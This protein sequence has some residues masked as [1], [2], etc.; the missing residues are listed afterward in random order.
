MKMAVAARVEAFLQEQGIRF[1]LIA[2]RLSGS[3]HETALSAHVAD[4][5]IAKAVVVRDGRGDALAVLPGD[6]WLDL[7]ALNRDTARDFRLGAEGELARLFPD[8]AEG[9]VP[10]V[11]A[12]YGLETFL[13]EALTSLANVYFEAGDHRHLVHVSGDA[14]AALLAGA[15]RGHFSGVS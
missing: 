7:D 12:A 15:R 5:H 6:S 2:H 10:A 14:F 4:D 11:G 3:T 9:A 8:C 1:E 13:D